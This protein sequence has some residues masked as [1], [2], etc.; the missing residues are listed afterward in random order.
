MTHPVTGAGEQTRGPGELLAGRYRLDDLLQ[1]SDGGRLW[2]AHDLVL[3]RDVGVHL[4]SA[5]DPRADGLLNAARRSAVLTDR[6][7]LRVLDAE[8]RGEVCYV[9]T[10]WA[11]GTTLEVLLEDGPLDAP[12]ASWVTAE[13]GSA[14]AS[15]HAV[16]HAHG[17]LSPDCVQIDASGAVRIVGFAVN[18]AL[19]G[20]PPG[21]IAG[22]VTDLAAI[23]YAALTG[24][25]PGRAPSDRV[26]AAPHEGGRVLR[27]RQVRAGVPRPLDTLCDQVLSPDSHAAHAR[28]PHDLT[29]A[30]GISEA[31]SA[32]VG[33]PTAV[34]QAEAAAAR[35]RGRN[36]TISLPPEVPRVRP[37]PAPAPASASSSRLKSALPHADDFLDR[38]AL[39]PR[40]AGLLGLQQQDPALRQRHDLG[41]HH[42]GR[43]DRH[44]HQLPQRQQ[45]A[46]A[47]RPSAQ[48]RP[49]AVHSSIGNFRA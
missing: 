49:R 44:D 3:S 8:S 25:W 27:A 15:A 26:P 13:V 47:G 16:G 45:R 28:T 37:S 10:E 9:V 35:A 14:L 40:Q 6:R 11:D 46:R 12:R 42:H 48:Q 30:L 20:L 36:T 34:S 19:V 33:D 1:E 21:E 17:R 31:L 4:I 24:R 2:R 18:A 41:R 23:L 39:V 5:Q 32:F 7:I 43:R 29:T 22:D 38:H